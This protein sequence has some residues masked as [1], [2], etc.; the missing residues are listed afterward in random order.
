MG[1]FG[2]MV[3]LREM[4]ACVLLLSGLALEL[5]EFALFGDGVWLRVL[6]F[7]SG[8]EPY[9][10]FPFVRTFLLRFPLFRSGFFFGS[11]ELYY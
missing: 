9:V 11:H 4:G 8:D 5:F 1:V 7:R 3:V 10:L 6:L 2:G